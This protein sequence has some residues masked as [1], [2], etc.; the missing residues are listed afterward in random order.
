MDDEYINLRDFLAWMQTRRAHSKDAWVSDET[1]E[2]VAQGIERFLDGA[3]NPWPKKRGNKRNPSKM[4]E[5]FHLAT[6]A[7]GAEPFMTQHSEPGGAYYI[8][9]ERL[10]I[11]PKT[12]ESHVRNARIRFET[13]EGKMEYAKWI[14][15]TK[16]MCTHFYS[17]G[18]PEAQAGA[19]RRAEVLSGQNETK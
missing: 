18:S 1:L 10:K 14:R 11:S 5:C 3:N 15:E 7:E 2:Y 8:V 17:K 13:H 16:G 4:W 12:V 19:A 9:G 6:M